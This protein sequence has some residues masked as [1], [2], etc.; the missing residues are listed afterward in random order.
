MIPHLPPTPQMVG[1]R[2]GSALESILALLFSLAIAFGYSWL[3]TVVVLA[4]LP[5]M[6]LAGLL[7]F[8]VTTGSANQSQKAL[9]ASTEVSLL[10]SLLLLL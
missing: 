10:S 8:S 1:I 4:F 7:N 5:V 9:R 3:T 2:I 6:V